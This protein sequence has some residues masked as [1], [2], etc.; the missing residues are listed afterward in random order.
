MAYLNHILSFG[1]LL[2]KHFR[3]G[4]NILHVVYICRSNFTW[5]YTCNIYCFKL[6]LVVS[7]VLLLLDIWAWLTMQNDRKHARYW[8]RRLHN[9]TLLST[10]CHL[11]YELMMVQM[12]QQWHLMKSKLHFKT[13][14]GTR[15]FFCSPVRKN[16]LL[17]L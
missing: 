4:I 14:T 17:N 15:L 7:E 10:T 9:W 5:T 2:L 1:L 12:E 13:W 3:N 11:S 6:L 8:R 16:K